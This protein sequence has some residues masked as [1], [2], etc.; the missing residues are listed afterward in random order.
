VLR[1]AAAWKGPDVP[2]GGRRPR[3]DR[4]PV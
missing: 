4:Y 1:Q 2:A 3:A